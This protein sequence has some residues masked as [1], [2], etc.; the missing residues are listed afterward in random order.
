MATVMVLFWIAIGI[1]SITIGIITQVAS[2]AK[3]GPE[4]EGDGVVGIFTAYFGLFV[5]LAAAMAIG[6][7]ELAVSNLALFRAGLAGLAVGL[8][9]C[10]WRFAQDF[11]RSELWAAVKSGFGRR[12]DD[13]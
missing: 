10:G 12:R 4:G 1:A 11:R 13:V 5:L 3:D 7:Y 9:C 8:M 6:R 2:I